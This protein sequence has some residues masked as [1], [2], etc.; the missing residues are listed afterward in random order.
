VRWQPCSSFNVNWRRSFEERNDSDRRNGGRLWMVDCGLRAA[1]YTYY[2]ALILPRGILRHRSGAMA[3]PFTPVAHSRVGEGFLIVADCC[4]ANRLQNGRIQCI[5]YLYSSW[6]GPRECVGEW[7]GADSRYRE[8]PT[9][10]TASPGIRI[11][12]PRTP[13][14]C[15]FVLGAFCFGYCRSACRFRVATPDACECGESLGM[16]SRTYRRYVH[17][18][19]NSRGMILK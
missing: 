14:L 1:V 12:K 6:T 4:G 11:S 3:S 9:L 17:T 2:G 18:Q 8:W 15:F 16:R 13:P 10:L 19:R 5:G 7:S